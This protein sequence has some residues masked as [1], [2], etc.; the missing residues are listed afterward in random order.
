MDALQD[1]NRYAFSLRPPDRIFRTASAIWRDQGD[2]LVC[3]VD[4]ALISI[5]IAPG[6][7]PLTSDAFEVGPK[8][9]DCKA[10]FS[11]CLLRPSVW[12][13]RPAGYDHGMLRPVLTLQCINGGRVVNAS[14][15]L[16]ITLV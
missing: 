6:H 2:K 3:G 14:G 8:D 15:Q 11:S 12:P 1:L 5:M 16:R 13:W 7:L 10:M 4:D 9:M